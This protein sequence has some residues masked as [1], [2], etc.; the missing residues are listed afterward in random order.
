MEKRFGYARISTAGQSADLQIDA[1]ERAGC[2]RVF[3]DTASGV[4]AHRPELDHMIELLREGDVVVVWRLDRLGRSMQNLVALMNRFQE[5]GVGF[6]SLTESIDTTTPGG[7]L[8]FNLFAA[9]SQF[10]RDLISER[11]KAGLEAARARGRRGGRPAKVGGKDVREI[12]RLYDSRILTVKQIADLMHVSRS[13]VYRV[14]NSRDDASR[15]DDAGT[16]TTRPSVA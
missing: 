2:D 4:K 6:V 1:L 9:L 14:L 11:T 3:V 10:E 7:M 16:E 5:M 12:R 15:H 8:T 13:T